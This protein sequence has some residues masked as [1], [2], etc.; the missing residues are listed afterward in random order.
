MSM[1]AESTALDDYESSEEEDEVGELGNRSGL[2]SARK[3][4]FIPPSVL[5][6][7]GIGS[8][9]ASAQLS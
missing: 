3:S 5:G 9:W 7:G 6:E 8:R 1:R 2:F 4:M